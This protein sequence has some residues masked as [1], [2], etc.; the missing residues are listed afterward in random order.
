M[1]KVCASCGKQLPAEQ[2]FCDQCG[3]PW[4]QPVQA[5]ADPNISAANAIGPEHVRQTVVVPPPSKRSMMPVL[6]AVIAIIA[7]GIGGWFLLTNRTVV[8]APVAAA[9]V[10]PALSTVAVTSTVTTTTSIATTDSQAAVEPPS[11]ETATTASEPQSVTDAATAVAEKS[12]PCSV[13]TR[14]EMGAILGKKIVKLTATEA[15][16]AYFTDAD[17]SAQ[18]DTI[19]T[20]GKAALA[21]MKGFNS[22]EGLLTVVPGIG[23]EAYSQAAGVLH[24]LK[25]DTYV[26][27][28]SREYP[29]EL[30]IESAIA[31]KILEKMKK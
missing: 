5:A 22:G 11:A 23:D 4:S 25:G 7:L 24:V 31:R 30:E 3:T 26:V 16:C 29:N 1:N 10:T 20:G 12:K 13:I 19:W 2:V 9:V 28:N 6:I 14:D 18:V 8:A 27:V 21:E 15:T 17:A